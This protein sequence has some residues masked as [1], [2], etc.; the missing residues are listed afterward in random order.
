MRTG[1]H[2]K[3]TRSRP[4]GQGNGQNGNGGSPG[5]GQGNRK[6][7]SLRHH[8]FDS[9][10]PDI[11]VRGTAFQVLEKYLALA[12]DATTSGDRIAAENFYQHAEHYYRIINASGE[13]NQLLASTP[14][15]IE[16]GGVEEGD[17][18]HSMPQQIQGPGSPSLVGMP[19]SSTGED[20]PHHGMTTIPNLA[21]IIPTTVDFGSA[22]QPVI[23]PPAPE[24]A[25]VQPRGRL[26]SHLGNGLR[27][28][29]S[30]YGNRNNFNNG[31]GP[32]APSPVNEVS[33]EDRISPL[34]RTSHLG[35]GESRSSD[36]PG[37]PRPARRRPPRTDLFGES[38]L[39]SRQD[40][41]QDSG[42]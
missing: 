42:E 15:D 9:N 24:H 39:N 14:R 11:R 31:A 22:E 32:R 38:G 27:Q 26:R 28:N 5:N 33:V 30:P 8:T 40:S 35:D 3:R 17:S 7:M 21:S 37:T 23:A 41:A 19:Y 36:Y 16:D 6:P 29:R 2:I 12:R 13:A 4:H 10:G 25:E 1:P 34:S 18:N 20:Q